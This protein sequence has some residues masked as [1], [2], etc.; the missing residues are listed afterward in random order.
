VIRREGEDVGF[1]QFLKVGVMTMPPALIAALS[2][3][4]LFGP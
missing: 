4:L 3:R 1:W 2:T